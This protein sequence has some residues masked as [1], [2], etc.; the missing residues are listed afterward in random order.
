MGKKMKPN[1]F[2]L[3]LLLSPLEPPPDFVLDLLDSLCVEEFHLDAAAGAAG[4]KVEGRG[5]ERKNE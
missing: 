3:L 2:G 1:L 4:Q 5:L